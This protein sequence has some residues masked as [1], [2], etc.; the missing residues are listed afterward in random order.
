MVRMNTNPEAASSCAW[1]EEGYCFHCHCTVSGA[2]SSKPITHRTD[3]HLLENIIQTCVMQ[4]HVSKTRRQRG[5]SPLAVSLLCGC[6]S[7]HHS[8]RH[9][10]TVT[11][12]GYI[13]DIFSI[14]TPELSIFLPFLLLIFSLGARTYGYCAAVTFASSTRRGF[15]RYSQGRSGQVVVTGGFFLSLPSRHMPI[16]SQMRI[17]SF[18]LAS[19]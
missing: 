17:S 10:Q 13:C 7:L 1:H 11:L 14:T 5:P 15:L 16:V 8:R 18:L 2:T 19:F 12:C 9:T 6:L 3:D 4:S